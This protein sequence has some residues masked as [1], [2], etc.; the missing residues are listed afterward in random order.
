MTV[1]DWEIWERRYASEAVRGQVVY[2]SA[3]RRLSG[4]VLGYC[5]WDMDMTVPVQ[6]RLLPFGGVRV[7]LD[8]APPDRLPPAGFVAPVQPGRTGFRSTRV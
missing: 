7:L 8:L 6:R 2:R 4:Y 3:P 5:G 1:D